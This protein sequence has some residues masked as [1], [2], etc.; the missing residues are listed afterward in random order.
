MPALASGGLQ[1]R[2]EESNPFE[3]IL[4]TEVRDGYTQQSSS[5]ILLLGVETPRTLEGVSLCSCKT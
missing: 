2:G 5:R 1:T 3:P 4:E